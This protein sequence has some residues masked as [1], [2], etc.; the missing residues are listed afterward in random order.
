MAGLTWNRDSGE[1]EMY[2]AEYAKS[3]YLLVRYVTDS[4]Y[5]KNKNLYALCVTKPNG[6]KIH[7]VCQGLSSAKASASRIAKVSNLD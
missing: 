2:T 3:T 4:D 5:S 1:H 6:Q 7:K